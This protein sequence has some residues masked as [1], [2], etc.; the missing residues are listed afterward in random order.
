MTV[1]E[2]GGYVQQQVVL[3]ADVGKRVGIKP[4]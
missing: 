2:F 3:W 1:G 4:E